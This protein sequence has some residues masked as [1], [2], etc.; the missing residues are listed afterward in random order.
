MRGSPT[1]AMP[2]HP[3]P[4]SAQPTTGSSAPPPSTEP[5]AVIVDGYSTG[6]FLPAAFARLSVRTVHVM[7]S[8]EPMSRLL[9]P[10]LDD[11]DDN[12]I[13]ATSADLETTYSRL[14]ALSPLAVL[15][16]QEP[17]VPLADLLSERLGLATNGSTGSPAR[18]DKFAMIATLHAAGLRCARQA[19]CATTQEAVGWAQGIESFPVVVKP[20]SSA[21]TDHVW[22]C[23]DSAEVIAAADAILG[24]TDIF[25]S[26]NRDVLVQTYLPGVEYIVDTVSVDGHRYVCGVWQY[27]KTTTPEGRPVYNRDILLAP[28]EAPVPD[29][30]EYIDEVLAA[31]GIRHGPAHAEVIMTP[32]GPAL[33]EIGARLN[34]NMHP[35]FH[36]RC[37]GHNQAD[38][39][40]LAYARPAEFLQRFGDH[41]YKREQPAIVYNAATSHDGVITAVEDTA[42]ESISSVS[43]VYALQVKLSPGQR[44]RPTV[45]L[46]TSPVRIFM[47]APDPAR[48]NADYRI[49]REL[50]ASVYQVRDDATNCED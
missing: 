30:I 12:F 28:D 33:V 41:T 20:L 47:T 5:T 8:A 50:S 15:A 36:H 6:N 13:A 16:G 44:I 24:S 27:D 1:A 18:R 22:I 34:G 40:A 10:S 19:K 43:S 26:T 39:T 25:G 23:R 11:Y 46:L 17:G 29:L 35:D 38:L 4:S 31:L 2:H 45:D 9:A 7:S 14:T 21:S 42:V 37:L 48:L 32:D 3:A 49:V